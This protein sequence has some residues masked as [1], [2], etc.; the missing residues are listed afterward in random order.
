VRQSDGRVQVTSVPGRGTSFQIYLPRS[1]EKTTSGAH[2]SVGS[3]LG[4]ETV[5][6]VEDEPAVRNLVRAVLERKGY[7]VLVAQD[8]AVAL[9]LVDKHTGVIHV[10]LTD[11]V[12][13]GMNGRD[14][15]AL[16]RTRRPTIKVVF[17]SGYTADVPTEL[18]TEGGPV[19]LSKPFTEQTLTAKLREALDTPPT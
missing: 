16:V 2:P 17:M 19:F 4:T 18:G 7:V 14:L 10:L 8:G 12:M 13:P 5:L 1:D 6:V 3:S 11:M 15:A 9:D